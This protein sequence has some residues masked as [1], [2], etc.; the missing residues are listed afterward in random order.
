MSNEEKK[1]TMNQYTSSI[2]LQ[3]SSTKYLQIEFY[4]SWKE[5]CTMVKNLTKAP[6]TNI[7]FYDKEL[8]AFSMNENKVRVCTL[9][10][11]IKILLKVQVI[12]CM[13]T[14]GNKRHKGWKGRNKT[15]SIPRQ[16]DRLCRK[17]QRVS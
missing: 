5:W 17:S 12:L 16:H 14:K 13:A 4:Y 8:N 11:P 9:T 10:S 3:K 1:K 15:V 2:K 6:T 7:M